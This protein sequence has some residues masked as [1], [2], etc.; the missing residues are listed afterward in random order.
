[1]PSAAGGVSYTQDLRNFVKK[2]FVWIHFVLEIFC[3]ELE[4]T[5]GRDLVQRYSVQLDI[6]GLNVKYKVGGLGPRGLNVRLLEFS[7]K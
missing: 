4:K 6:L 5:C 1:M 3:P 7:V 2:H